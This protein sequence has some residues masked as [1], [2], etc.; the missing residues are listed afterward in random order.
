MRVETVYT[1]E[2]WMK[3]VERYARK[4]LRRYIIRKAQE[5][6]GAFVIIGLFT[7]LLMVSCLLTRF[8]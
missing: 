7:I 6:I 2:E 5:L 4:I 3:H 1:E 8:L